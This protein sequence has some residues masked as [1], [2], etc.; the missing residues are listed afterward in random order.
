[1][2][3]GT[4][5][6]LMGL[7]SP[8]ERGG[9][10]E[11]PPPD[12]KALLG[13]SWPN[14]LRTENFA[15]LYGNGVSETLAETTAVHLEESWQALVI[16]QDWPAP[17][18]SADFLVRVELDPSLGWT[19]YT[20]TASSELGEYPIIQL[21]PSYA[22][23]PAFYASL[24]AHEFAHTL[25]FALRADY[26][27]GPEEPWYWEASAEWAAERVFPDLNV[28][29]QQVVYYADNPQLRYSSMEGFH[30]YGMS[31]L[32]ASIE[33]RLE[34]PMLEVWLEGGRQS[35][36]SWDT[37]LSD[38][39][40]LPATFVVADF[41]GAYGNEQLVES[42]LY[43]SPVLTALDLNGSYELPWL[44]THYWSAT[45]EIT[46]QAEGLV[47]IAGTDGPQDQVHLLVGDLLAVTGADPSGAVYRLEQVDGDETPPCG[48]CGGSPL[49]GWWLLLSPALIRWRRSSPRGRSD[50][51]YR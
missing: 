35:A 50:C 25:H 40:G 15:V 36:A 34:V 43:P 18:L 17:L 41:A 47:L 30:A 19:G 14:E 46:V 16:E 22:D 10:I 39:S 42:D 51:S 6:L 8:V 37:I 21:N 2:D 26:S 27:A 49:S 3:C 31:V 7:L 4:P 23:Y 44:G 1:M 28:Y 11:P 32:N 24:V 13:E 12:G 29:S 20:V 33:E 38:V 9:R 5:L 45:Q 48:G